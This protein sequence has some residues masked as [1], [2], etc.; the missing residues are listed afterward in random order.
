MEGA[1]LTC[2]PLLPSLAPPPAARDLVCLSTPPATRLACRHGPPGAPA[3][4]PSALPPG[5]PPGGGLTRHQ[6]FIISQTLITLFPGEVGYSGTCTFWDANSV[7]GKLALRFGGV[8]EL[9]VAGK[10]R[11]PARP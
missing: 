6:L 9:V 1:A 11:G 4:P 2:V 8:L 10:R 3:L 7:T 5:A